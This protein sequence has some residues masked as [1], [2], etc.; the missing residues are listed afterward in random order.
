M[1]DRTRFILT[2]EKSTR[3]KELINKF[4]NNDG[5]KKCGGHAFD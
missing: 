2:F 5:N 4:N 1:D 3:Y